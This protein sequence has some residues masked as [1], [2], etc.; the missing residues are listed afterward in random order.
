MNL[1]ADTH[2]PAMREIRHKRAVAAGILVL[3][4][5]GSALL[6]LSNRGLS[7]AERRLFGQ[8]TYQTVDSAH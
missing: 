7:L 2:R 1:T 6:W 5:I 8:W 4:M 3:A